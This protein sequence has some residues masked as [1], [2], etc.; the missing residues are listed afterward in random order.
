MPRAS[1]VLPLRPATH[2]RVDSVGKESAG[3]GRWRWA[4]RFN[5]GELD[6]RALSHWDLPSATLSPPGESERGITNDLLSGLTKVWRID[7]N[8]KDE[9]PRRMVAAG[10]V[11]LLRYPYPI[12][13]LEAGRLRSTKR[14]ILLPGSMG[15]ADDILVTLSYPANACSL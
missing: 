14:N 5:V 12:C 4:W 13:G 15:G 9:T 3:V 8:A 10:S 2:V 7:V 11:G 6:V 1:H